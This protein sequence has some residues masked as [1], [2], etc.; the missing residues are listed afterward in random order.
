MSLLIVGGSYAVLLPLAV[1][2]APLAAPALVI[3]ALRAK[4]L[5]PKSHLLN[6]LIWV[7]LSAWAIV[8]FLERIDWNGSVWT[9]LGAMAFTASLPVVV[10]HWAAF[11]RLRTFAPEQRGPEVPPPIS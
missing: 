9:M 2:V 11:R 7:G 1:Y 10:S 4:A 3:P 6:Y 5:N 8:S